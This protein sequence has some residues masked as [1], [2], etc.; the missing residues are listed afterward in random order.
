[1]GFVIVSTQVTW[2]A[3]PLPQ[4]EGAWSTKWPFNM[5][6]LST[7]PRLASFHICL[8]NQQKCGAK[9]SLNMFLCHLQFHHHNSTAFA[10]H[11]THAASTESG[12][13]VDLLPGITS[14][15]PDPYACTC[16]AMGTSDCLHKRG[17]L[18]THHLTQLVL[19]YYRPVTLRRLPQCL[20]SLS[21]TT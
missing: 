16:T 14:L 5:T 15:G 11:Y 1:M 21:A 13:L 19:R 7:S 9:V 6:I 2:L 12:L 10:T 4:I 17:Q 20:Y 18:L 3:P 8:R